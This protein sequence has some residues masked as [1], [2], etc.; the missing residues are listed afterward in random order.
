MGNLY[1]EM[2]NTTESLKYFSLAINLNKK[3]WI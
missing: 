1:F 2:G 3:I